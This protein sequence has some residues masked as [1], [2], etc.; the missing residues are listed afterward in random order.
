[1][2]FVEN[3]SFHEFQTR[4]GHSQSSQGDGCGW[5]ATRDRQVLGRILLDAERSEFRI[6]I[7]R[8]TDRDWRER[9][10]GDGYGEYDDAEAVLL[11]YLENGIAGK[12]VTVT[13]TPLIAKYGKG[14]RA[15]AEPS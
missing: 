12:I 8:R 1:M 13:K 3:I 7:L 11:Q 2:M 10:L 5:F 4:A 14:S 9:E 6:G 15:G